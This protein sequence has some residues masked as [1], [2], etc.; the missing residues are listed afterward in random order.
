MR[1]TTR[2]RILRRILLVLLLLVLGVV[3]LYWWRFGVVDVAQVR[4]GLH[5]VTGLGSNVGILVTEAGVVV[6]DTMTFVRQGRLIRNAI[7]RLTDAPVVAVINT[8]YHL[9]HTHGNPAFPVGTRVVSTARTL[10]HLRELDAGYWESAP[11]R[12]LMPNETF[13]AKPKDRSDDVWTLEVGGKTVRALWLGRGHTDGDLVVL[14]VEDRVL[15][16]GDLFFNGTWPNIDLEA[17]GSARWWPNTL[18]RVL[19]LDFDTVIPGHG[20][21]A[22]RAEL[23]R[24]RDFMASLWRQT[25]TLAAHG[26]S[27]DDAIAQVDVEKWGVHRMWW[28][29]IL[30]RS[31]VIGRAYEEAQTLLAN[32]R[33]HAA[34]DE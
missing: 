17:G 2:M 31:F 3:G 14:F 8:H 25:S 1:Y 5:V 12:D 20:P 15:H 21:V 26:A 23:E 9:D 34:D 22:T 4:P 19:A 7:E 13:D 29:P 28:F 6:V 11:A 32:F 27:L 24:F 16:V 18:D 30:S 10:A 33:E